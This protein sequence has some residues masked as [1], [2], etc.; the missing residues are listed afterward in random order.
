VFHVAL[1]ITVIDPFRA[2]G[3]S[4]HHA[5]RGHLT[6]L[7]SRIR[8][9]AKSHYYHR[10]VC[11]SVRIEKLGPHLSDFHKIWYSIILQKSL[12]KT[13]I[14]LKPDKNNGYFIWTSVY[15]LTISCPVLPRMRNVSDKICRENQYTLF[16]IQQKQPTRCN[17]VTEFIIPPFIKGSTCFERYAAHHQEL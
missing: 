3:F 6:C 12:T 17:L 7:I 8:K 1:V 2:K 5:H 14:S 10:H 13:Q 16:M 9:T 11:L 15:I 4:I